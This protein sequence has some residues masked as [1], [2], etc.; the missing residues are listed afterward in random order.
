SPCDP[1]FILGCAP[2]NVICSIIFH[3]RFDYKDQQ[4]L[5]LMEKFNENV[6]I[7]S[8]PWIQIYNNF[9]PIIDY[10]P[11][12]HNKLLKNVAFVK[13][14]ILEKVK[15]HQESMDMNN[16]RDFIDC[17]LI[18]MEKE[19]HNQQ[20]EFT[21]ENLEN[22]VVDL[23]G[24]GTETTSTTL[25]YALLLLLKHPEVADTVAI[26]HVNR[27]FNFKSY[28][29]NKGTTILISLSSVLHDNKEFPNPEMFDPHHFLDEG[30]NFKKSNY[31]MPFSAGKR[32][33]VGEALARMELFLFLTS[34]LQNFNLKSLVDPKDLDTTPVVNGFASVPPKYQLCFIPV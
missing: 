3:K 17:F 19:K 33:C 4:F 26:S 31:F 11:G 18:K 24:A 20:S 14:Y 25:R 34:I 30:G 8:S 2:C 22:T 23:F 7:L 21:I 32:I 29:T 12:T 9:S 27:D 15:E 6:K 28:S 10:L 16:P 13:S 5:N 1:T